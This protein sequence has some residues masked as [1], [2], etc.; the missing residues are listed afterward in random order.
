[1]LACKNGEC[2]HV[3][4][5]HRLERTNCLWMEDRAGEALGVM[6][7]CTAMKY[8]SIG[9]LW[10]QNAIDYSRLTKLACSW[11]QRVYERARELLIVLGAGHT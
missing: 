11:C 8:Q 10:E 6:V 3:E 2:C 1:M 5:V 7:P 9:L 4:G